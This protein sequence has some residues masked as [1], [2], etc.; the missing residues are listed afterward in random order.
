M[1]VK[2][3]IIIDIFNDA[4]GKWTDESLTVEIPLPDS[5]D[6]SNETETTPADDM[7]LDE[8]I[9]YT[10]ECLEYMY[11][12]Y[13]DRGVLVMTDSE[14]E[15]EESINKDEKHESKGAFF[16]LSKKHVGGEGSENV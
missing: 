3:K 15:Y 8:F 4:E 12:P 1:N 10:R 11:N 13:S 16:E 5:L 2:F 9:E 14:F 7:F 6:M